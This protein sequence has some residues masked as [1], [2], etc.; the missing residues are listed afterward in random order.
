MKKW[1]Y[2][3]S[4]FTFTL[5]ALAQ[6]VSIDPP[7]PT[8][9]D[10]VTITFN[11]TEGNG[12]L[13]NII[14]VYA[15]TGVILE[16]EDGWQNVQGEWGTADAEVI[17]TFIGPNTHQISY[18]II[19]FYGL[20]GDEELL[21]LSFVFRNSAGTIVGREADGSDI[22][23]DAF[24]EG[25]FAGAITTPASGEIILDPI[26]NYSFVGQ[27]SADAS[28]SLYVNDD[29]VA[30]ETDVQSI[31]TSVDLT[32]LPTGQHWLW[33]EATNGSET[34]TDSTFII[35]QNDP[36][37]LPS[38]AGVEDGIN[39]IDD[40]TVVLQLNAPNKDFVYVLGDFNNWQFDTDY[41]MNVT[42]EGDRYWL[43]IEDL[44]AGEEYRFQYSIDQED[45]RI[46]DI[47]CEKILDP[48]N[49]P[50]IPET[51][52]PDLIDYPEGLT[53]EIVGV[54]QTA[55]EPYDWEVD[56]FQRPPA[57]QLV[58]YELLVR[59]FLEDHSYQSLIDTLSYFERLEVNA[60][61]L[62]PIMEFEGNISWGYNP[63]FYFAP[64]KYYGTGEK[65]KEFIDECHQRGIAVILDQVFNHS[66]GQNPQVRMYSENG[67]AGPVTPENPWFNV[68]PR[69]DFNVG[70]DYN[71]DNTDVQEFVQRNL[72]FWIE[73]YKFDGFRFDLSKGFTQNNTLGN[74]GAWNAVDE[75]RLNHW[76]RIR[77]EIY[78]YDD[79]AYLILEHLG[80]NDEETT[81]A[82]E[83]FMLWGKM[84]EEYNQNSMGYP[85]NANL[86]RVDYQDRGWDQPNL[87]GYA[88]SHDEQR[89]MYNNLAFGNSSGDY[90][91]TE[92]NTALARQEA[93]AAFLYPQRGPKMLWQFGELGYEFHINLCEDGTTIQEDCRT[94]PKPIRWDYQDVPE[95]VR[96]FKVT[97]ALIKLK[98]ENEAFRSDNY[99]WDV[100]GLG[101]RLIIQH[102][103]MDVVIIANFEVT[104]IS[105]V[106][107]FTQTGTWYDYFTGESIVENNLNNPF[108]LEPG[109]Y[110]VYTTVELE[111]PDIT[112]G[113]DEADF[114]GGSL[115][116]PYPNPFS[117]FTQLS[118]TLEQSAQVDMVVVDLQGRI[119]RN[120]ASGKFSPGNHMQRWNARDNAGAK[121]ASG[122]YLIQLRTESGVAT[123][124]VMVDSK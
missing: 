92:L 65:L 26:T 52:Y 51:N 71:H 11:A 44:V 88:E 115:D 46:A 122:I 74:I 12:A 40:N 61:Q 60:I 83:G 124:K 85:S 112:L 39:Y 106:P 111:T 42:P 110:R 103:Q 35:I 64:D 21:Q 102:P 58:I 95:R 38:P 29:I 19:D 34:I 77:D 24:P 117:D 28:I 1:I 62:M 10:D 4:L 15:H 86:A 97:A 84:T 100:G 25:V 6:V 27:T 98:I 20:S 82:S 30:S 120:L 116:V 8:I 105:I 70:Y 7:F 41:L 118:F 54:L 90:N 121:V 18:N 13:T 119:V 108:L 104:P 2:T 123:T 17:M 59:D 101:K 16:G 49:D 78:A 50:F 87:V 73:E 113:I 37:V 75:S 114:V 81:L 55:Q 47:Y 63:M 43:E 32:A 96:L 23:I 5:G 53:T 68:V 91:V 9:N 93:V 107:G 94:A 80:G 57:D 56:N 66:F 33:M 45:L 31:S 22:F 76:R 72:Q 99:T 69:H 48:W 3:I 79:Q 36:T 89:L 67:A 109:E 14:P